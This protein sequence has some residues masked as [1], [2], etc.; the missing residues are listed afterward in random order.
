MERQ[1]VKCFQDLFSPTC[2]GMLLRVKEKTQ[3]HAGTSTKS[4]AKDAIYLQVWTV[5]QLLLSWDT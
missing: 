5:M 4:F 1:V 3:R 2:L